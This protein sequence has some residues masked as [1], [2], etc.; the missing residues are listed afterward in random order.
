MKRL[1]QQNDSTLAG[2]ARGAR[3]RP[4]HPARAARRLP[5]RCPRLPGLPRPAAVSTVSLA[6]RPCPQLPRSLRGGL[7]VGLYMALQ[8]VGHSVGSRAH[9]SLGSTLSAPTPRGRGRVHSPAAAGGGAGPAASA[10]PAALLHLVFPAE[11]GPRQPGEPAE[12]IGAITSEDSPCLPRGLS[13]PYLY[14]AHVTAR[15]KRAD[16]PRW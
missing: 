9:S 5:I 4:D 13:Q 15:Q 16:Q 14:P 7:P 8:R 10:G 11:P 6:E 1:L 12:M 3:R 2:G